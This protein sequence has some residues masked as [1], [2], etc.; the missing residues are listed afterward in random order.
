MNS[1]ICK[2][3]NIIKDISLF[4]KH[5]T[6]TD[7]YEHSC[8]AC[9]YEQSKLSIK[10]NPERIKKANKKW[11]S[12]NKEYNKERGI[13]WRKNNPDKV[14]EYNELF[15]INN[16]DYKKNYEINRR[17]VDLL[18]KLKHNIH[19]CLYTQLKRGKYTKKSRTYKIL[20]CSFE[21]FKRYLES[22]F[23]PWMTWENYGLYNG[24]LNYGW[25][26]D[27]IIPTSSANSELEFLKLW[28]FTNLQ[29]LCSH[30]NRDIKKDK[31]FF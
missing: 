28:N 13:L 29:P 18:Y 19:S 23:E 8:K 2:K 22:Q 15:K 16:P 7:G 1:K 12:N 24:E 3:C 26:I 20:G 21:D 30:I 17:K 5:K 31:L 11:R 6:N 10:N 4:N 25:D 27:H 14:K 9:R